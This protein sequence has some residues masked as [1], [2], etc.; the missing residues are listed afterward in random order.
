M[1][2]EHLVFTAA[3]A[4]VFG[5]FY[6]KYTGRDPMWI[7]VV[8]AFLPDTDFVFQCITLPLSGVSSLLFIPHGEFHN[9]FMLVII[10]AIFAY[11]IEKEFKLKFIDAF[12]YCGIGFGAHIF[13]DALVFDGYQEFAP[14]NFNTDL[15]GVFHN[16]SPTFYGLFNPYIMGIAL[17]LLGIATIIRCYYE[18]T[19][20]LIDI[21]QSVGKHL[22]AL[23]VDAVILKNMAVVY[24]TK[25]KT[26][27]KTKITMYK[28]RGYYG[29][30]KGYISSMWNSRNL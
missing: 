4:V 20:W 9:I 10:S 5:Y 14:I 8:G 29:R 15:W 1:F 23:A 13:E 25:V 27:V 7:M 19:E 16:Y 3:L 6:K 11:F 28:N 21:D 22:G 18:G 12:I 26:N 24:T 17:C 30:C 2:L